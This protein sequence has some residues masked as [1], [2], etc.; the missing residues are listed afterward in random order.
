[1]VQRAPGDAGAAAATAAPRHAASRSA[2]TT[3]R[4]S[5]RWAS[6]P[7]RCR[8]SRGS[9]CPARSS[10][11]CGCGGRRRS[12]APNGSSSA[13]GTP[14]RIYFKDESVSPAG[15]HKPNTA[16]PQAFYN[17]AEG[18]D[19]AGDRDRCRPVGHRA[20]VRVRAVRPRV[21]GVHGA[22]VVR[23]EAVPQDPHGDV[24]RVGRAV[25][26]RP[27]RPSRVRSASRSAT[28]CATPRR[29]TT[30]TTPSA[31]CSTTCC[32]TRP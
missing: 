21:Q 8:W 32:C 27:T 17:K 13:L 29:A 18:I 10:T 12:S 28:R 4:R 22:G 19:A 2:P 5:S 26:R 23:A 3:S 30:R 24:G 6:S 7:R 16:V 9:T 14:A 31:R 15:S 11:S 1:M 25:T 20:V